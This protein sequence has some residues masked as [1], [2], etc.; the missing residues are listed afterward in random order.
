MGSFYGNVLVARECAE[1]MLLLDGAT[2]EDGEALRGYAFPVGPG[3]TAICP[4]PDTDAIRL[5][6]PLSRL[7]GAPTLSVDVHDS[8]VLDMRVYEDGE[9]RHAYD[10]FPGYFDEVEADEDENPVGLADGEDFAYPAPVGVDPEAFLPLAAG[11]VDRGVLESVLRCVPR[12]PEDGEEGRY[13]FADDQHYD[14]METL[15]LDA[16]RLCTGHTYLSRG[17]LP[18]GL[19]REALRVFGEAG[20]SPLAGD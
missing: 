16:R 9:L 17:Q 1:V 2:G 13:V 11:S 18:D 7:L 19:P 5:A 12:D 20:F 14:V 8:D 3:H 10:S 4:A 6:G 15:G